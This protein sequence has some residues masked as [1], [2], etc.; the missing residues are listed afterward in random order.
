MFSNAIILT[1]GISLNEFEFPPYSGVNVVSDNNGPMAIQFA[2]PI[3]SFS[4]YFTYAEP[5]TLAAFDSLSDQVAT[6]TSGYSNNMALSGDAGSS[7][8]EFLQ[9]AF[10]NGISSV[11]ITGDPAG[12]SFALDDATYTTPGTTVPDPRT[13][14]LLATAFLGLIALKQTTHR[15]HQR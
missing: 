9:V 2:S 15:L 3:L 7:P 6:A 12:G 14:S 8:N 13:F 11:T 5:L 1:A 10:A 4:G